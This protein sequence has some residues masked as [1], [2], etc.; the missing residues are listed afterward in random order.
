M[1]ARS[2]AALSTLAYYPTSP[3]HADGFRWSTTTL[4]CPR[5][6]AWRPVALRWS[7]TD[8][9]RTVEVK[10]WAWT[11]TGA[12]HEHNSILGWHRTLAEMGHHC[13]GRLQ[14]S[15]LVVEQGSNET[16]GQIA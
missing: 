16:Y 3:A 15:G 6:R 10:R 14:Q 5:R 2:L 13:F 1:V 7:H 12:Y 8:Q 4:E 9:N 11:A